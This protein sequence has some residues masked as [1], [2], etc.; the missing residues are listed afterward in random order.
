M[1]IAL[2]MLQVLL[3]ALFLWHGG[4]MVAPP[5]A[6]VEMINAPRQVRI[7]TSLAHFWLS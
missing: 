7:H 1:N 6:M 2:W 3:A 5:A 4:F